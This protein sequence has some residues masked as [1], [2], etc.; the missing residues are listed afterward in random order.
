VERSLP[1]ECPGRE[2]SLGEDEGV[3][4]GKLDYVGGEWRRG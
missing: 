1:T 3:Y 2:M 4:F